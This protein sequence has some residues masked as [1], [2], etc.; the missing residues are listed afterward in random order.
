MLTVFNLWI[1][2]RRFYAIIAENIGISPRMVWA[3]IL[4]TEYAKKNQPTE[5][6]GLERRGW[7]SATGPQCERWRISVDDWPTHWTPTALLSI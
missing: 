5:D 4:R 6:P 7:I 2:K 1:N 3:G